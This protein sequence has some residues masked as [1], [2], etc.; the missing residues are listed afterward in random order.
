M[1]NRP[2]SQEYLENLRRAW[3]ERAR[4]KKED[5]EKLRREALLK[6]SAAAAHLKA[7][8][9]AAAVYLFGSLAG[10]GHF[11]KS[12]DIDLLVEGFPPEKSYWRMLVELE[13]ITSPLEVSVVLAEDAVPGLREKARKEGILL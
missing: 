12:S 6:A 11:C 5:M 1:K 7:K 3:Q 8:Y 2:V 10:G 9:G 13:E 4:R